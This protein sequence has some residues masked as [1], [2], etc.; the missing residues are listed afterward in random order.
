LLE[1][2]SGEEGGVDMFGTTEF[3]GQSRFGEIDLKADNSFS[4]KVPGNVPFHIQLID[5]F[6]MNVANESIWISGRSGEQRACGGCHESRSATSSIQ[7]GLTQAALSSAINLDVPRAQRISTV[8]S[9]DSVRGVPWNKAIQPILDAKCISCHDAN[10]TAGVPSYTVTDMTTG[11]S[12]EFKFDLTGGQLDVMVGERMTAAFSKSYISI[13]GLGEILGEDTVMITGTVP[14]LVAPGSA[15]DSEFIQR[16]N[17]MQRF[18]MD[19]SV[20][21]FAGSTVATS[22]AS[23]HAGVA[24]LTAD[25]MYLFILNIDMGGQYFFRENLEDADKY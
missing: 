13:M 10:N 11:T 3:D 22:H 15:K 4:A 6:A 21:A 2:F 9:Y 24:A 16:L 1:G 19:A 7:P 20:R 25:E 14:D 17:P 5:K 8:Y 23:S 18:P 12:Q